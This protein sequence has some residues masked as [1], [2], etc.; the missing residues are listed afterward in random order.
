MVRGA[1]RD[2]IGLGGL[3]AGLTRAA[4][5]HYNDFGHAL[6]YVN[7]ARKLVARLGET[8]AEPLLLALARGLVHARR[9]DRIPE[10]RAYA[11]A[12]AR[13]GA[14]GDAREPDMRHWRGLGVAR[15]LEATV[16]VSDAAPERIHAALLGANAWNMLAFDLERQDRVA[17]PVSENVGWLDFTHGITFAN[18]VREQCTRFP[19]LWPAGLLQLACFSGRNASF[20][21]PRPEVERWAVDDVEAF[22]A[23]AMEALFDHGRE[24][25][26]VS[27]H[28]LKTVLAA[29]AEIRAGQPPEVARCV[30][31]AVNRFLRS[32]MKR[33]HVRRTVHQ[34]MRF[35]AL[36]G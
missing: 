15:A 35:V 19:G 9:E 10:F 22:F 17:I 33:K 6:I 12:L 24:E 13:W 18:A 14:S 26:I 2:G 20:T 23:E 34:A 3:E 21:A 11:G 36:D 5:M 25:F 28:L 7:K 32:P 30:A 16:A 8:V 31:A 29:R 27:V 1:L 4:L